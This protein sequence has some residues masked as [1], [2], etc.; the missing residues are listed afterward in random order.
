[1][2]V[3]GN[4]TNPT[5]QSQLQGLSA[6]CNWVRKTEPLVPGWMV[7]DGSATDDN[8]LWRRSSWSQRTLP[9]FWK[10]ALLNSV[11]LLSRNVRVNDLPWISFIMEGQAVGQ[12][13]FQRCITYNYG[14]IIVTL[15]ALP[16]MVFNFLPLMVMLPSLKGNLPLNWFSNVPVSTCS[17]NSICK[18]H[19]KLTN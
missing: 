17:K 2:N 19:L 4:K 13:L 11:T 18:S 9:R 3:E 10:S 12:K 14:F 15:R 1:M 8:L 16:P 6:I 7:V 5:L